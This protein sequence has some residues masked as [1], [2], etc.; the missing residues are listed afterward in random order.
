MVSHNS[1]ASAECIIRANACA[2]ILFELSYYTRQHAPTDTLFAPAFVVIASITPELSRC[3]CSGIATRCHYLLMSILLPFLHLCTA[4]QPPRIGGC[5]PH[6]FDLCEVCIC[7]CCICKAIVVGCGV[8]C[9]ATVR[10]LRYES[11]SLLYSPL[12]C[13][14]CAC[15]HLPRCLINWS[16]SVQ[17]PLPLT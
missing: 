14:C 15:W 8:S 11:L 6:S 12:C 2:A 1:P 16:W 5:G 17:A 10:H 3:F 4:A 7:N 13:P 9:L